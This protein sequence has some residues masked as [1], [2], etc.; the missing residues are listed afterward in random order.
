MTAASH[1]AAAA[2]AQAVKA[3]GAIVKIAPEDFRNLL[4]RSREPL[5]V[6]SREWVFGRKFRYLMG[7]KGLVFFTS[8]KEEIGL[9]SGVEVVEAEK[10]WI[11]G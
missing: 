10:I 11:P 8:S 4:Q 9:P 2:I 5:V 6:V 1:A 7:Y 3:S